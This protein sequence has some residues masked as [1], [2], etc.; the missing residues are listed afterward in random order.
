MKENQRLEE[1]L[2]EKEGEL[3]NEGRKGKEN[4]AFFLDE[5]TVLKNKLKV[6]TEMDWQKE[7][8]TAAAA[9]TPTKTDGTTTATSV[10]TNTGNTT[11]T[12]TAKTS[13]TITATK[14]TATTTSTTTSTK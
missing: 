8:E 11:N 6:T 12:T 14:T 7:I 10:T 2:K 9:T 3:E 1:R 13:N 5:N 4:L